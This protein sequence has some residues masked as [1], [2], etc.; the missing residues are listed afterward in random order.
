ME[1]RL[2]SWERSLLDEMKLTLLTTLQN[3][4]MPEII[5]EPFDTKQ[6]ELAKTKCQEELNKFGYN[7]DR[8]TIIC[9]ERNNTKDR[10]EKNEFWI[11]V[12]VGFGL[13]APDVHIILSY[14]IGNEV[15]MHETT[16]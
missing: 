13:G 10:L 5:F 14:V 6:T 7:M 4:I 12:I 8:I 15:I 9:D 1:R 3:N 11:E 16:R 2:R